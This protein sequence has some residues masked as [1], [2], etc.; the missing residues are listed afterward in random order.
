MNGNENF[1]MD[2][3]TLN[4]NKL[5][6][7]ASEACAEAKKDKDVR[8][9]LNVEVHWNVLRCVDAEYC[10]ATKKAYYRVYI[11]GVDPEGHV[12]S[13]FIIYYLENKGFKGVSV[14]LDL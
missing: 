14:N 12:L 6:E 1:N 8:F 3:V 2:A 7:L 9:Y 13:D 5:I 11:E 10:M 4:L